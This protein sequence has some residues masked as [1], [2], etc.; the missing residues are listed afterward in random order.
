MGAD[1][2]FTRF[3]RVALGAAVLIALGFAVVSPA[4]AASGPG[5]TA[6]PPIDTVQI[7]PLHGAGGFDLYVTGEE[8]GAADPD[9]TFTYLSG[10]ATDQLSHVYTAT[11]A[12]CSIGPAG[13]RL[14][15]DVPGLVNLAVTATGAPALRARPGVPVGCGP[16]AGPARPAVVT[17]VI[18]VAIHPRALG[19]VSST[20]AHVAGD[21]FPGAPQTCPAIQAPVGRVLTAAVGRYI[22]N[23]DQPAGGAAQLDILDEVGDDP[24]PGLE[25]VLG[26]HLSGPS[27]LDVDASTGAARIGGATRLTTGALAFIPL[28]PCAGASAQNGSLS[29]SFT[30]E[31]PVLGPQRIVGSAADSAYSALGTGEPGTCNGPGSEPLEP[32]LIDTCDSADAGCSVAGAGAVVTFFDETS[33]GTQTITAESL[34]FGDGSTPVAI[35]AGGAVQH[36]YAGDG[37]YVATL[38]VTDAAGDMASTSTDVV[39]GP[40]SYTDP[41]SGA[42]AG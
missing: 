33:S 10:T 23:A 25:G 32:E 13:V 18:D 14:S 8:C 35:S 22:I 2:L 11:G 34:D 31:D 12:G 19:R 17:G 42:A 20:G 40:D 6:L 3:A 30:I 16:P 37:T 7:G 1:R 29:G 4:G 28:A 24:A 9:I 5:A 21:I 26:L 39:I 41:G 15:A 38:T 36:A 27:A